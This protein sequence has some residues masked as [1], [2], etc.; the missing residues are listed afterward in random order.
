M[1]SSPDA[2][3][4]GTDE[5]LMVRYQRGDQVAFSELVER[6]KKVV[7]SVA[8]LLVGDPAVAQQLSRETFLELAQNAGSFHIENAF[9]PWLFGFF[10]RI[11]SEQMPHSDRGM[12]SLPNASGSPPPPAVDETHDGAPPSSRSVRSPLLAKRLLE[13][14][15]TLPTAIREALLLKLVAQLTTREIAFSTSESPE[16]VTSR[17]RAGLER[18][19]LA[20]SET[21]DYARALR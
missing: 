2:E 13:R 20:I 14:V 12:D 7:Y 19:Q 5:V 15:S 17:L 8:I 18:L 4:Q 6:H 11:A 1:H 3:R 10:H 9:R 16:E 21:E